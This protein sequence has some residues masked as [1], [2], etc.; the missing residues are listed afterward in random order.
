MS[1]IISGGYAQKPANAI[2]SLIGAVLLIFSLFSAEAAAETRLYHL[3][4]T[5]RNGE[6]YETISTHDPVNYC[7]LNGGSVIYLRDYSLI[8]SQEMK[9]KVMRTWL[10]AGGNQGA[11]FADMLKANNMLAN[12]NR[13]P[14]PRA[15]PLKLRDMQL[16]E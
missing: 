2:L 8:Y 11:R 5:L 9:V 6:R 16:P 13:R 3:R 14:L 12:G 10:D 4:V 15:R 7:H 1:R